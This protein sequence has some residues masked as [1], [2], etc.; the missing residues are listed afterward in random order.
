MKFALIFLALPAVIVAK[1]GLF[2]FTNDC[3]RD[4][5]PHNMCAILFDDSGCEG[6]EYAVPTGYTKLPFMRRNDAES[7]LVRAGCKLVGY[8]HNDKNN[9][10]NRGSSVVI[11]ATRN[12][13]DKYQ[14]LEDDEELEEMISAVECSCGRG[15][16]GGSRRSSGRKSYF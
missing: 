3:L 12:R 6:W 8:D 1:P 10:L 15:E 11:D 5:L 16:Y 4:P 13:N 9:P 14:D 7:V 2:D